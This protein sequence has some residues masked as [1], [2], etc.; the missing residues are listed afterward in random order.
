MIGSTDSSRRQQRTLSFSVLV[1]LSGSLLGCGTQGP[2]QQPTPTATPEP[3]VQSDV[4]SMPLGQKTQDEIGYWTGEDQR[5][6]LAYF[7]VFLRHGFK[8]KTTSN[9]IVTDDA[10]EA[11]TIEFAF[12]NVEESGDSDWWAFV[13]LSGQVRHNG[14]VPDYVLIFDGLRYR[15]RRGGGSRQTYDVPGAGMVEVDLEYVLW[16]N[17]NEVVAAS[18]RLHEESATNSPHAS[19]ELFRGL[20]QKMAEEIVRHSP[21]RT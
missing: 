17:R 5:L 9:V 15:I 3:Q 12:Q 1:A 6:V 11:N 7:D 20:F 2:V 4:L 19:S 18:G 13:P 16:D 14:E 21:L 8:E 10:S